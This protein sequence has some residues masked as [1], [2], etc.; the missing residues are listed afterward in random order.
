MGHR[1]QCYHLNA[2]DGCPGPCEHATDAGLFKQ[3]E[4]IKP[5]GV[6][7]E[8]ELF[9]VADSITVCPPEGTALSDPGRPRVV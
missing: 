5:V 9:S 8:G 4:A 6:R 2:L 3:G 7:G 1:M